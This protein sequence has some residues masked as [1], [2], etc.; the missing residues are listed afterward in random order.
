VIEKIQFSDRH[1]WNRLIDWCRGNCLL[2]DVHVGRLR[3]GYAPQGPVAA[4][5][6]FKEH[7]QAFLSEMNPL[8]GN[9]EVGLPRN[10]MPF[11]DDGQMRNVRRGVFDNITNHE[12]QQEETV[13][14]G[15]IDI[16]ESFLTLDDWDNTTNTLHHSVDT[17]PVDNE[18]AWV[19]KHM[20]ESLGTS[21]MQQK[22]DDLLE[23]KRRA[24]ESWA[25]ERRQQEVRHT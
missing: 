23:V 22:G 3:S 17:V 2:E 5:R 18:D 16:D 19:P 1:Q 25:N 21:R 11:P 24:N 10:Q 13:C 15:D 14:L 6:A 8:P 20:V 4:G 9:R 7:S 12:T